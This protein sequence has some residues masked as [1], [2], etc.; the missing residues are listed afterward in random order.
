MN[1]TKS[2]QIKL[3]RIFPTSLAASVIYWFNTG[4]IRYRRVDPTRT[5]EKSSPR[6]SKGLR[7]SMCRRRSQSKVEVRRG[8]G[9]TH[10]QIH[11]FSATKW[12]IN[13]VVS[14]AIATCAFAPI[15]ESRA[16]FACICTCAFAPIPES[17]GDFAC[18]CRRFPCLIC[19]RFTAD[20]FPT[21]LHRLSTTE[22]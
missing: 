17:R 12:F 11:C 18:A 21:T 19:A 22:A 1:R 8:C 5:D 16:D 14:P 15:P 4:S 9:T 20:I 6:T 10:A 2:N 13:L 7:H 3:M